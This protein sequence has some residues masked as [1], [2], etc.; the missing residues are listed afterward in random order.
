MSDDQIRR[1]RDFSAYDTMST[2]ELEQILRL[3]AEAPED[4]ASDGELLLYVME[5]LAKRKQNSE[6]PGKTALNAWESFQQHYLPTE[7]ENMVQT[8]KTPDQLHKP[9]LRRLTAAAA[10]IA[11]V[12]C[13]S[14]TSSAFGWSDIWNAVAKWA[15]ETFSFV[16]DNNGQATEPATED[17][18]QYT[19]LQEVLAETD[20]EH[21]FVP[22]WI[23]EGYK[24]VDITTDENPVRKSYFA[25]YSAGEK[26][27]RIGVQ[28]YI[29][30]D[31]E[32]V[33]INGDFLEIYEVSGMKY[34]IYKNEQRFRAAWT[35]DSYECYI[36]GDL[37]IEEIKMMI[38]S[39]GK[40]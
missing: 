33:E 32:K 1:N 40:G 8:K 12:V 35:R 3:D 17:V 2:E 30:S 15:K 36:S 14:A 27:L 37:T 10:V 7:E 31:P 13:L 6:N 18:Q 5:V 25:F 24:L 34:H 16:T 11:L 28:S 22:T 9:W 4:Q 21:D 20:Q 39:I 23:P 29:N 19:S 38:N 26:H